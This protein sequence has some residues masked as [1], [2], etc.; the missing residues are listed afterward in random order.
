[1]S[2]LVW[3]RVYICPWPIVK[4]LGL[5]CSKFKNR[6]TW[7]ASW[8]AWLVGSPPWEDG[9][10]TCIS[11]KRNV[12]FFFYK[13]LSFFLT[14]SN[15][16][17]SCSHASI[18]FIQD[19]FQYFTSMYSCF[20]QAAYLLQFSVARICMQYLLSHVCFD[21]F[22]VIRIDLMIFTIKA[23]RRNKEDCHYAIISILLLLLLLWSKHSLDHL[24]YRLTCFPLT[25]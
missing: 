6:L 19:P 7:L 2:E 9:L 5:M 13:S 24:Q 22:H 20:F 15:T 17:E 16:V 25:F 18:L 23:R 10:F 11:W 4:A 12:N 8:S 3:H 14:L 21:F 1:M